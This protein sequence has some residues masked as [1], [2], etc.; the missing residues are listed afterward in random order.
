MP[1]FRNFN[2]WGRDTGILKVDKADTRSMGKSFYL[3]SL[4]GLYRILM[5]AVAVHKR[6][7]NPQKYYRN[8]ISYGLLKFQGKSVVKIC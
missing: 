1:Y 4:F 2:S 5:Y 7:R 6:G 8:L 3:L